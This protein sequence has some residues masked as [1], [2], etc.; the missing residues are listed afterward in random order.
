MRAIICVVLLLMVSCGGDTQPRTDLNRP[1]YDECGR[2]ADCADGM[3]CSILMGGVCVP[4]RCIECLVAK[5][6]CVIE[7]EYTE[8]GE[9][10]T[11][12]FVRCTLN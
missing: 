1:C 3:A 9:Y 6:E 4:Y 11:C 12:Q 8:E 2:N 5:K 10:P 7:E